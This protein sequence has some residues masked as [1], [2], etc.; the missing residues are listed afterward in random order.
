MELQVINQ[1]IKQKQRKNI[2]K[3]FCSLQPAKLTEAFKYFLQGMGY[4]EY[5]TCCISHYEYEREMSRVNLPSVSLPCSLS[6][7]C[8]GSEVEW[9]DRYCL[10]P[11]HLWPLI[12][13]LFNGIGIL[14]FIH[15]WIDFVMNTMFGLIWNVLL[16]SLAFVLVFYFVTLRTYNSHLCFVKIIF[17]PMEK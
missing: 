12:T 3:L 11:V 16:S 14:K 17:P 8:E 6:R 15:L 13:A 4:S 5:L 2:T 1:V 10:L 9:R 7:L